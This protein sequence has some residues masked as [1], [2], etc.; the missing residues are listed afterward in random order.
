MSLILEALNRSRKERQS[1]SA[2]PNLDTP[3][4][5]E[6]AAEERSWVRVLPWLG[7]LVAVMVIVLLLVDRSGQPPLAAVAVTVEA[8]E[9][10]AAPAPRQA[11]PAPRPPREV[12]PLPTVPPRSNARP[13]LPGTDSAEVAALYGEQRELAAVVPEE[14]IQRRDLPAAPK[15]KETPLLV[16]SAEVSQTVEPIDIEA[17]LAQTKEGLKN[18]D[19]QEHAAPFISELSQQEKNGI[20]TILYSRHDYSSNATQSLVILNGASVKAGDRLAAGVT[21]E[22]ILPGSIVLS[23]RGT[24]FRLRALNS[25]VNL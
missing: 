25:W 20:P 9:N 2:A 24:Q 5:T 12:E 18:A 22:E 16:E 17:V 19:L 3:D 4:Y 7:L 21:L 23:H 10:K 6:S 13:S 1:K 14:Q 11:V 15:E 8:P